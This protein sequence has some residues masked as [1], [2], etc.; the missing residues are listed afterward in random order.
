MGTLALED[1]AAIQTNM[2]TLYSVST[3][4]LE[5]ADDPMTLQ[6]YK[7]AHTAVESRVRKF[8]PAVRRYL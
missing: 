4:V 7:Q 5:N 3:S 6:T 2:Q 8:L 1:K